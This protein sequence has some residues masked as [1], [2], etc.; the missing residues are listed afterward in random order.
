RPYRAELGPYRLTPHAVYHPKRVAAFIADVREVTA[1]Q[2]R[3]ALRIAEDHPVDF[4]MVHFF[5]TDLAQ[6]KLWRYLDATHPFYG[7]ESGARFG[8][9]VRDVFAQIDTALAG[10]LAMLPEDTAVILMS[11]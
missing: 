8:T 1:A 5:M 11:D 9:A 10:L 3:Y 2:I 4:L 7:P 6:H